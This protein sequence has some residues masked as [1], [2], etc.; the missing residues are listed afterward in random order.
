MEGEKGDFV[1]GPRGVEEGFAR[2]FAGGAGAVQGEKGEER[3]E[4]CDGEGGR[5]LRGEFVAQ[6]VVK[7]EEPSGF[8]HFGRIAEGGSGAGYL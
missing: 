2:G 3:R 1:M 6:S 7:A 8:A 5:D 4:V